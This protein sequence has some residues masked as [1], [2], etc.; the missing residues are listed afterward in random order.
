MLLDACTVY[1]V[2]GRVLKGCNVFAGPDSGTEAV[3]VEGGYTRRGSELVLKAGFGLPADV[4]GL[5]R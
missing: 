2:E 4:C 3:C 5:D 1:V